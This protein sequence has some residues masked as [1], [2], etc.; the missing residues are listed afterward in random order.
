MFSDEQNKFNLILILEPM[1]R[2][3]FLW[4]EESATYICFRLIYPHDFTAICLK[5][6]RFVKASKPVF[7]YI[8]HPFCF[9]S[10]RVTIKKQEG[11]RKK[12]IPKKLVTLTSNAKTI[13]RTMVQYE[14][15]K[16]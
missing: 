9:P 11:D 6:H 7:L 3:P 1:S 14:E 10:E 5:K 4:L 13:S 8:F 2:N 15:Q 12:H 16:V